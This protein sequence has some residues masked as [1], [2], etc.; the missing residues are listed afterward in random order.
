[1]KFAA[2]VVAVALAGCGGQSPPPTTPPPSAPAPAPAAIEFDL[3]ALGTACGA[4]GACPDGTLCARYYGIAG[5]SGPEFSSCEVA[6]DTGQACPAG[7][8]CL[9]IADGPGAVCRRYQDPSDAS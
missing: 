3:N 7:S 8:E 9:T 2:I 5:A 1:M 4:N 6:C